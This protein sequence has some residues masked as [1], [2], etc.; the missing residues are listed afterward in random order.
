MQIRVQVTLLS[1]FA[2]YGKALENG[3]IALPQGSTV[4][5]LAEAL[6][7]PARFVVI[8][9]INGRQQRPH[10]VLEDGDAVVLVPPAVGGG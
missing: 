3:S 2:V 8:L 6:G 10:T 7:I 1:R 4:L 9:L 5:N